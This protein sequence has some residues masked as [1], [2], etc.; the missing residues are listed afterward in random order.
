[1]TLLS[2]HPVTHFNPGPFA[3]GPAE[4]RGLLRDGVRLLVARPDG[5]THSRFRDLPKFLTPGDLVVVND[6]ATVPGQIDATWKRGPVIVHLATELDDR[7]WVI[8]LRTPPTAQ[9]PILDA[10]VGDVVE[11]PHLR[12]TLLS[13]YPHADSS[14]TGSGDRL[15]TARADG[16]V[17]KT[18]AQG[19]PISYGYLDRRYPISDYQTVFGIR[20]GSA[21]MASAARPFTHR[22]VT[23]LVLSGVQLAPITLHTGVS[24]QEAG[25]APQA[26]RFS[27]SASTARLVNQTRA[28]G[29]R[30]VAVGTTVVRALESAVT[31]SGDV[32]EARGWTTRVV[33]PA[34]PPRIVNGLVTGW[35]DPEA[36][37]LLLVEAVAGP[38]LSQQAY[39][40]AVSK[41]YLWHEFGDSALLLP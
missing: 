25:E 9:R 21:E 35:H 7:S 39:D 22:V 16:D 1:M 29:G 8:E 18:L 10:R 38:S 20:P 28:A 37:H 30:I 34:N 11:A 40:A 3:V 12:L 2:E 36:S 14:P 31:T 27:V 19:R 13:P 24:S 26:E 17:A 33:T 15:W 23:A 6:S 5:I 41:G 4:R 32:V